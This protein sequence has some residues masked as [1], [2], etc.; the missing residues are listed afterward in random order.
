MYIEKI[1]SP[2]DVKKLNLTQ[3]C[4]LA[5]E[6]RGALIKKCSLKGGHLASNLGVVEL[7]IGLHYV[8][9]CP[10]DKIIFDVSHQSYVHKMLTGRNTAFINPDNYDDVSG[11]SNPLESKCDL[12]NIGHTSTSISLACGLMK[13]REIKGTK[14]NIIAV[15]GD[16]ALDGGQSFEGLN[17]ASEIKG[18]LIVVVNDNNMSIPENHG[19]LH[20]LLNSLRENNGQ[21]DNNYF[22]ALGFDYVFIKDGNDLESVIS[23]FKKY[24]GT[25]H[26]VLIHIVTKKGKGYLPAEKDPEKWHWAHPFDI[27]TGEFTN[28]VPKE[29]YGNL[30]SNFL[31][32]K[33]KHD[34]SVVVVAASTP[35]CIGFTPDKRKEAGD[36]YV[37][38]GIAEQNAVSFITGLSR[39]GGKPVFATNSTFYQRA[40]DQIEQEL[41][42]TKC[43]VTMIVTHGSVWGHNNNTHVGLFDM[44]LLGNIPNLTYLAPTNLEE[45][46]AM[47]NWSIEQR[48]GP[49]AI[50][51]PWTKVRHAN[52]IK[53]VSKDYSEIHFKTVVSG[54]KIAILAL[55]SFFELGE[56][57]CNNL[58]LAGFSPTLIN[59][60]FINRFNGKELS[61]LENNHDLIVSIEDGIVNGGFGSRIAQFYSSNSRMKVLNFGF[62]TDIPDHYDANE[63]ITK[64]GLN[65]NQI[66]E[67]IIETEKKRG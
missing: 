65:S 13:A 36:Q 30:V 7:T 61:D 41:C 42:I 64:N 27:E 26:H 33:I 39:N 63:F 32:D 56:K 28:N 20:S 2:K 45:Y 9:D 12:F 19:Q 48:E 31:L 22:K 52:E 53:S 18:G 57:V 58:S 50:R 35:L 34:R 44:V 67:K 3:L 49:V 40:Y 15:I 59:P 16:S 10:T 43:P 6:I 29:N 23:C 4:D 8:F 66:A 38:V 54:K 1:D 55:G 11:Y 37:D 5:K 17:F 25:D 60:C 46:L 51:V 24:K 21:A 14:E 62:S 47:L